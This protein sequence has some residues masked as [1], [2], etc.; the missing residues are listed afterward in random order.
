MK[1]RRSIRRFRK[2]SWGM[3]VPEVIISSS[4]FLVVGAFMTVITLAV[5]REAKETLSTLPAEATAYRTMDFIRGE[6][7]PAAAGSV[8]VAQDG[9]FMTFRNP[10]RSGVSR[11]EFDVERKTCV[12][13]PDVSNM[14][15]RREW[16]R[17]ITGTFTQLDAQGSR[18]RIEVNANAYNLKNEPI[19][20]SYRDDLTIRN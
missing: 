13:F 5:G 6:L 10:I 9:S 4:V 18:F 8:T 12:F 17:N 15:D 11:I 14:N 3:T 1:N 19:M 7:L 2:N 16:G 20:F